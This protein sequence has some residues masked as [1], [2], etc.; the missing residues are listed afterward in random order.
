MSLVE[1]ITNPVSVPDRPVLRLLGSAE[2][3]P[4]VPEAVIRDVREAQRCRNAHDSHL[5]GVRSDA[6]RA[7]ELVMGMLANISGS[8]VGDRFTTM[9][10]TVS[11]VHSSA[12]ELVRREFELPTPAS[13]DV[14]ETCTALGALGRGLLVY[15]RP[16]DAVLQG[17]P[18]SPD[19]QGVVYEVVT[20]SIQAPK[21]T[22]PRLAD[23]NVARPQLP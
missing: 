16:V 11:P 4:H 7:Q 15:R 14:G 8:R 21:P 1:R 2:Q 6:D 13:P 5:G 10:V 22:V 17:L 3:S 23:V 20:T 9:L 19:G 12:D 18:P